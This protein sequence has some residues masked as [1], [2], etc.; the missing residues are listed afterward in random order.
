MQ[1]Q[2][3]ETA[4]NTQTAPLTH[5]LTTAVYPRFTP[6]EAIVLNLIVSASPGYISHQEIIRKLNQILQPTGHWDGPTRNSVQIA[7]CNIRA[8]L[9]ERK[10][11]PIHLLTVYEMKPNGS[12]GQ[13]NGYTWK[14]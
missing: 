2:V 1:I 7:V 10:W 11:R 9:G 8:K 6:Q 12:R 5:P 3:Q 13:I 4:T 14:A